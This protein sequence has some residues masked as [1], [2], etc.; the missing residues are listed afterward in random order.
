MTSIVDTLVVSPVPEVD[1]GKLDCFCQS[2][3]KNVLNVQYKLYWLIA[4]YTVR[5]C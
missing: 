1:I 3:T 2:Q 4:V 5:I